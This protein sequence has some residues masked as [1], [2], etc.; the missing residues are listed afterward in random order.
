ML[1]EKTLITQEQVIRGTR[2]EEERTAL[3]LPPEDDKPLLKITSLR[4]CYRTGKA[5]IDVV[6]NVDF[7]IM[8]GE[9]FGLAGESGSGK[10]TVAQTILKLLPAN[11][12]IKGGEVIFDGKNILGMSEEEFRREFRWKRIATV[13]QAAMNALTPVH[14]I[15]SQIVEAIVTHEQ[16]DTDQAISRADRLLEMVRI[17]KDRG[18]D[19]PHQFSGGMKQRAVIAMSLACNPSLLIADEPTTGLDVITQAEV[20]GLLRDLKSKL[21]L[22]LLFITH[23]ISILPGLCD[24]VAIM[25]AGKIVEESS[26]ELL[27]FYP[28]HPYT[29]ALLES[30]PDIEKGNV[31]RRRGSSCLQQ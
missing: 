19:F 8:R 1:H 30:L 24:R 9:A 20:L 4:V 7:S 13:P 28:T 10:S 6:D 21:E 2:T 12:E 11:A 18:R 29:K 26:P 14:R 22:S 25:Y 15:R 5:T 17:P 23:D 27:F 16:V 3:S 31:R